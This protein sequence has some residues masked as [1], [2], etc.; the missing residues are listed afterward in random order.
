MRIKEI[1]K[2]DNHKLARKLIKEGKIKFNCDVIILHQNIGFYWLNPIVT[3]GG[4]FSDIL[5]LIDNI[6]NNYP[7]N[8]LPYRLYTYDEVIDN[9]GVDGFDN[10][11][12]ECYLPVNGGEYYTDVIEYVEVIQ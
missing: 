12:F 4:R 10:Y 6:Y 2:I 7:K 1:K 11:L 5:E 8:K 9:I 3:E